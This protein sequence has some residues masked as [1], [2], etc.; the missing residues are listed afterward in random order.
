MRS[1]DTDDFKMVKGFTYE[2]K[3]KKDI[4]RE[5]IIK[6]GV[7]E[8]QENNEESDENSDT[9]TIDVDDMQ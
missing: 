5:K 1:D 3:N 6:K 4:K 9:G 2:E 7:S 8:I